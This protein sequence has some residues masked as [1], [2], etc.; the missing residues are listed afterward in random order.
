EYLLCGT[1]VVTTASLGGR[2]RYFHVGN[3]IF[4]RPDRD[5][6]ALAVKKLAEKNISRSSIRGGALTILN[7]ERA[8][9]VRALNHLL[10][11]EFGLRQYFES[12]EPLREAW[13]YR[14]FAEWERYL[15]E[16]MN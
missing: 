13:T 7:F 2:Q 12:F 3:S 1:P 5:S 11:K 6:V 9:L 16:S 10:L 14:A 15:A 4:A 8:N